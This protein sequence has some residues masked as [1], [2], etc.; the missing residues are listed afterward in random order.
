VERPKGECLIEVDRASFTYPD[1]T[2]ALEDVSVEA[3]QGDVVAIIGANGSGKT[4]LLMLMAG[5]LEP[6]KGAVRFRGVDVK[7][8]GR[9]LRREVGVV[10]QDPDDQLFAPTV[11]DDIAFGLRM[12]GLPD[13]EV[14]SRVI[15]VARELGIE[16]ILGRPPF[17]LSGGEKRK[18]ALATALVSRP[19]V[20]LLD[21]PFSDLS[22]LA[23]RRLMDVLIKFKNGGGTVVFTSNDVEVVAELS[24]YVYVLSS[25]RVVAH[26]EPKS[27][28]CDDESLAKAEL[29][30]PI[31]TIL[32]RELTGERERCP[33][34]ISELISAL[35]RGHR[36]SAHLPAKL[37]TKAQRYAV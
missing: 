37:S 17:R 36:G 31:A 8:L 19:S 27:V 16:H 22:P 5:L 6:Q 12:L 13:E 21:E 24:D 23:S 9:E 14:R 32:Y 29:R 15:E 10:F 1:G 11:F 4:T 35:R 20:L 33:I 26:G 28:L 25:G 18:V 2:R 30:P 7:K 3:R 34:R